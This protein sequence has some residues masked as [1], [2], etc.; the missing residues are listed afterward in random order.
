MTPRSQTTNESVRGQGHAVDFWR[1][2]FGNVGDAHGF[3]TQATSVPR[4]PLLTEGKLGVRRRLRQ[5]ANLLRSVR[6]VGKT[7]TNQHAQSTGDR[8]RPAI[9]RNPIRVIGGFAAH[10]VSERYK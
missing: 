2:G 6:P 4:P 10:L 1:V 8:I 7:A 9:D 5:H 3:G